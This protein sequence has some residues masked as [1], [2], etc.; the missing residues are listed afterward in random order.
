[1]SKLSKIVKKN[2]SILPFAGAAS[3][4]TFGPG[5]AA[6][7]GG[8]GSILGDML[9]QQ[10]ANEMNQA[11][12]REQMAFQERMSST[13]HQREVADLKAAGL[14]PAL[15]ANSGA[16]S[17]VGASA[18]MENEMGAMPGIMANAVSSALEAKRLKK[19]LAESDSRINVNRAQKFVA[20]YNAKQMREEFI[21]SRRENEFYD[22]NPK[23]MTVQKYIDLLPGITSSARDMGLSLLPFVGPRSSRFYSRPDSGKKGGRLFGTGV[24]NIGGK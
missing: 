4:S 22:K 21:K 9:G 17:P 12:A 15:S 19:D 6:I 10:A 18:H 24:P 14:N 13:A 23:Y 20:L 5:G 7:G 3:G 1:M 2:S 8:L 16:S 11:N